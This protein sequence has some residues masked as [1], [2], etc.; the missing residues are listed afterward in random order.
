MGRP[1]ASVCAGLLRAGAVRWMDRRS[2]ASGPRVLMATS[3]GGYNHGAVVES[4]LAVASTLRGAPVDVLLCDRALP[5]CQITKMEGFP[6]EA[7]VGGVI[8]QRGA[9][10][11]DDG[12]RL[13]QQ[14]GIGGHLKSGAGAARG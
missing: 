9:R 11:F 7:L 2:T 4:V 5:L 1:G 10:C 8:P 6:P 12:T 14:L 13:C 3:L